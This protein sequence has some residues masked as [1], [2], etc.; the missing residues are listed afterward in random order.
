MPE[1]LPIACSLTAAELP[2][3]LAAMAA[4]GSGALTDVEVH[5]LS[6]RLRFAAG[7]GVRERLEEIVAAESECCAFL[8]LALADEPDANVLTIE[9]PADA[10]LV[11]A[12][13]VDA[14][15]GGVKLAS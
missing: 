6:A 15:R 13:L 2:G 14:F 11:L 7:P 5:A 3:R 10:E 12:E 1:S 8:T 4:V 9:A